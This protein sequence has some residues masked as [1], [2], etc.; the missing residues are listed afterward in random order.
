MLNYLD[1]MIYHMDEPIGDPGFL[2][3]MVLSK[4]VKKY[5]K[6]VLSGDGGDEVF[7]GYD[8][9]KMLHYGKTLRKFMFFKSDNE[10]LKKL[11]G[12]QGKDD[13]T[14][15]FEIIR[16]FDKEDLSKLGVKPFNARQ[17]WTDKYKETVTNAQEFDINT[18]LPNDFFMK[19][20]KM[21]SAFG[22][23]QRVPFLDH[24]VV[25]LAFQIPVKYKLKGWNEKYILKEAFKDIIPSEITSRRKHGFNVP[26]DYW[27]TNVLSEKLVT[28]LDKSSH[29]LYKKEHVLTLLDKMHQKAGNYKENFI[30][31]QK[32]WSILVFEMWYNEFIE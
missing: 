14:M 22:L 28:L 24:E 12:M 19:A 6:V 30:I 15:F 25:E 11:K 31:A 9:Y 17:Y 27:F 2:P 29:G 16:L 1:K 20:D 4:A 8:R 10:I 32:L 5:N 23:E 7:L 26:I 3:I 13:F 18:L 21:S